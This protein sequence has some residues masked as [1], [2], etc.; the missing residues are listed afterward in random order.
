M[1][2]ETDHQELLMLY[3]V[4]VG[5]LSY[6]KTQQWS[7]ATY[8]FLLFAGLASVNEFLNNSVTQ[9]ENGFLILLAILV[10]IAALTVIK[11][12]Q[13]SI[14]VRQARLEELKKH[15]GAKFLSVWKAKEKGQEYIR[16]V[17]FLNAAV[18]FGAVVVSYLVIK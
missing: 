5:D 12:L 16:S 10:L 4:T 17:W 9:R 18:V 3:Q 13:N 2:E 8:A 15:F 7:V 6:F 14:E 1:S 11:K